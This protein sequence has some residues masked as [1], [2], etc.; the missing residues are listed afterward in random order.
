M[1]EFKDEYRD[2]RWGEVELDGEPGIR[3]GRDGGVNMEDELL[4]EEL[5][6]G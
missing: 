3:E 5:W 1:D 6:E 4:L 2:D